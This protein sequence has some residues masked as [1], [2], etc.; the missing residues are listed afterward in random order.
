M[1]S[2]SRPKSEPPDD[3]DM[4]V[5]LGAREQPS[6]APGKMA[7][8]CRRLPG[9]REVAER[10]VE[11]AGGAL[12]HGPGE[13]KSAFGHPAAGRRQVDLVLGEAE[14][15]TGVGS[16]RTEEVH[17]VVPLPAIA[18]V[19]SGGMV[20]VDDVDGEVLSPGVA[21]ETGAQH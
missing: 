9:S 21:V 19:G 8:V 1:T 4:G 18:E 20:S 14:Q 6:E 17:L 2:G 10:A 12:L 3:P 13:G 11:A 5:R 16:Q 15:H 7:E